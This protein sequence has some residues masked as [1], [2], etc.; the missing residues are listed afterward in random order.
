MFDIEKARR[1]TPGC[2]NVLHFNNAGAALMPKIVRD[3]LV[4]HVDRE[5][6]IGGYEAAAQAYDQLERVYESTGKL[7]GCG[8]DEIALVESATQAWVNAFY[9][10]PFER[11]DKILTGR[12]EYAANY[13]AFLQI[14]KRRG[15]EIKVI[16]VDA[17]GQVSVDVLREMIDNRVKLIAITHIPTNGGLI[18]PAEQIGNV[19][20]DA[21][22]LYLLDA[23]QTVGQKP[24]AVSE[25]GCDIL[26]GTSRKY[27][28]GPR[29]MGFLYV[30]K[31]LIPDLEPATL[32][33]HSAT[34]VS[35][36]HYE[37][38]ADARRFE[39]W[40]SS[41]ASRLAFGAA[42]DYA[43]DWGMDVIWKRIQH[44]S[45]ALRHR[46]TQLPACTL[47]DLGDQ[48]CGIVTFTIDGYSQREIQEQLTLQKINVSISDR[49]ST[50][51]DM[52]ARG[53][54][55]IIRASIHYYNTEQE[56]N[57]FCD[58]L[59]SIVG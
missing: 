9:A 36:N 53:L 29:G 25:I 5:M 49:A 55:D 48:K 11:G 19:A 15:V 42:V 41:V 17:F 57:Q 43:L 44:L 7:V 20:R 3:T 24:I 31:Q 26:S 1:D 32:D 10:I 4:H 40:E 50:L 34:W 18:N 58:A 56:I 8:S 47:Q 51:L 39:K 22:I 59:K 16:P 12:A 38:R 2:D 33:L 45:I 37:I 52:D 13:I 35:R 30:K 28:R 23:C 46:L 21:G 27:L 14:A 6:M 54:R